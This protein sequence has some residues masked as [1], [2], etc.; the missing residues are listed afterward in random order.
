MYHTSEFQHALPS[1]SQASPPDPPPHPPP[2]PLAPLPLH[3]PNLPLL[4]HKILIIPP[5]QL[6]I[7]ILTIRWVFRIK[8]ILSV[9]GLAGK[10]VGMV[11]YGELGVA[12]GY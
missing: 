2:I 7:T 1:K 10:N 6:P 3:P 12:E 11:V 5:L 9:I 4:H 8:A